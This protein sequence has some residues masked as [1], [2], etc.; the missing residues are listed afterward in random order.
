[1]LPFSVP[2]LVSVLR[3]NLRT[4]FGLIIIVL[5]RCKKCVLASLANSHCFP[6]VFVNILIMDVSQ[7]NTSH[8]RNYILC[9]VNAIN[10]SQ[11]KIQETSIGMNVCRKHLLCDE[12]STFRNIQMRHFT[13]ITTVG[14]LSTKLVRHLVCR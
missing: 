1:M 13:G 6:C 5:F 4:N 12:Y 10:E 9:L 8:R 7:H 2:K 11:L 3:N 14:Y